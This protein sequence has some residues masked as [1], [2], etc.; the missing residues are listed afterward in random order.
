[1]KN[2][3]NFFVCIF[4]I[5]STAYSQWITIDSARSQDA[6]GVSLLLGQTIT[7][8]GVVTTQRELGRSLVYFQSRT[9]GLVG[10]DTTFAGLVKRGDSIEVTGTVVQFAGLTELQPVSNV[11]ILDTGKT[12]TPLVVTAGQ[13]R[14]DGETYEGRLI[15][16]RNVTAVRT[17]AGA[18]VTTW[19]VTGSG[20][21]YRL[22]TGNDSCEIRIYAT[23]NIANQPVNTFPFDV[24]ALCSQFRSS[25]PFTSG[26]QILPRSLADF[27]LTTGV[28]T[29][30][31]II[32]DN[33][34]LHQNYPNPFN[35]TTNLQFEIPASR[36]KPVSGFVSLKIYNMLGKEVASLVNSNLN[37]GIYKYEF[38]A[39]NLSSG[40]YYYK[41]TT[42]DFSDT[43]KMMLIK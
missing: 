43:K 3:L 12:V 2:L 30:S 29:V 19:T 34:S 13:V 8:R 40:I 10:F 21:N 39:S 37:P 14:L 7:T 27:S 23:T 22:F 9:A 24:V 16:I 18:D 25:A 31:D 17:F 20:T 41:L 32:P 35:P 11:T 42:G 28:N 38:D 6:Q 26:Y 36:G 33:Y 15:K 4:I 1:M 5:T